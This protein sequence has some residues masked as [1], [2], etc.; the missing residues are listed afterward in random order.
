V[1]TLIILGIFRRVG[2]KLLVSDEDAE[3]EGPSVDWQLEPGS[4]HAY[5]LR[6]LAVINQESGNHCDSQV[7][8]NGRVVG[9]ESITHNHDAE[10]EGPP[11]DSALRPGESGNH[12][13]SQVRSNGEAGG[14]PMTHNHDSEREGPSTD[15]ALRPGESGNHRDSQVRPNGEAG[16]N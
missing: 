13:D 1:V 14:E 16:G 6:A 15:S 2:L 5:E 10:R 12:R 9:G 11:I 8:P 7:R 4:R 3:R